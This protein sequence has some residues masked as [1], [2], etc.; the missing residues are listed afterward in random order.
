MSELTTKRKKEFLNLR[1]KTILIIVFAT[2]FLL[3]IGVFGIGMDPAKY[4]VNFS[5]RDIPPSMEHLFGTDWMGRDM[6]FRS[7][8]GMGTSLVI[9]IVASLISCTI[10]IIVGGLSAAFGGKVDKLVLWI[11]DLFQGIPQ[12]ILLIFISIIL[13]EGVK[14]ILVGVGV[15]H[16][17]SLAR[18]IRAEILSIKGEHFII[19]ARKLGSSKLKIVFRHIL[20]HV[21]PQLLVGTLLLFPHAILHESALTFL[22]FGLPAEQPAIGIILAESMR[23]ITMG[24][25]WLAFFP[26][27]LLLIVVLLFDLIGHRMKRIFNPNT[28]QS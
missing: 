10:A 23:Y 7:I 6:F 14:G 28:G 2:V 17:T 4:A 24:K 15:T 20:P 9:G 1:T 12:L 22:G 18:I 11:I 19:Q 8:K 5:K 13:G 16:W 26:G 25:W 21:A 27:L 3:F